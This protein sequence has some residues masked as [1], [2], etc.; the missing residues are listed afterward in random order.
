MEGR[1][2]SAME[3]VLGIG[4]VLIGGAALAINR[5]PMWGWAAASLLTALIAAGRLDLGGGVLLLI[6]LPGLLLAALSH[7]GLRA[8]FV[9]RPLYQALRSTFPAIS[10]T[11]REALAAGTVGWDAQLFRGTLDWARLKAIPAIHL[12]AEER[13]F[14]DGP[15]EQ[16][17]RMID[18]W[19]LRH[20]RR[21]VPDEVWDFIRRKGF[22]G[23]LISKRY[24]GLGFS[25]QA[26]SL[27]LGK[28][29]SRSPDIAVVVMVPNSLGP[30][31]LVE[32][33]GTEA[34]KGAYLHRLARG[35]EV[36]CFALTSPY[37]GSDA[38]S[39]RDVGF[40]CEGE[41]D[42]KQ[43][44]G[45]RL[46]WDKRYIT[47]APKATLLGL[48]F[49]L[50]DP[51][52]L[53]DLDKD[54]IGI[55]VALIPTRHEGVV[56]GHRH[57][58]SGAAF[59]NGPTSGTD[60]F[61]PLD[62]VIGG[63]EQVGHGW[64][65]LMES[66]AVGRAISLPA[67][68]TA[69]IKGMLRVTSAYARLRRQFGLPIGQ[70][71]GVEEPL[72]RLVEN[73]Y[74]V[75]AGRAMTAALVGA[76]QKPSVISALL[77]YSSTE[78]MRRSISDAMDVH[79]G[80]AI[81]D[82][83]ANYLMSA[84]QSVPVGITVEGANIL[85][86]TLI[87]FA[88]GALRCHPYLYRETEALQSPDVVRGFR[89]FERAFNEHVSW[90]LANGT[91]ALLHNL[92]LGRFAGGPGHRAEVERWYRQLARASRSFA[93]VADVTVGL[94]AGG[95]KTKQKITGRLADALSELYLLSAMLKRFDDDGEPQEDLVILELCARNALYRFELALQGVID[96][97]P[98]R[99]A[100]LLMRLVAQ[101]LGVTVKPAPDRLARKAVAGVLVP[102]EQRDR[103][104]R[105]IFVS[106]DE[107]DLTGVLEVALERATGLERAEKAIEK[108]V[109]SG[110]I[111]RHHRSDWLAEAVAQGI[112]SAEDGARLRDFE[113]L[114]ARV[115]GVDDFAPDTVVP[116]YAGSG[117]ETDSA[118]D[119][120]RIAAE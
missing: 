42:G 99:W 77:K 38:A 17:C 100:A 66:L 9:S 23:M 85:T 119:K 89:Q 58:P 64:G 103:L 102:G 65:M 29:A 14:L 6:L 117:D 60:V 106:H 39:M 92:T 1:E 120:S 112:I 71:E 110:R 7:S 98:I 90:A 28:I 69:A 47:L 61:I 59:P 57:L 33:Y 13:D 93:F 19:D 43:V 91:Q 62:W 108:A 70:M 107:R 22:L 46:T 11:E 16:L 113:R 35:D 27:I 36:P 116:H 12:T 48:A 96:N 101:P 118:V 86:R 82:G 50:Y 67:T 68:S 2:F 73:A 109:R 84:Y 20:N 41:H 80:R 95:L 52:R 51:E 104:T 115:V 24:G 40:V 78:R 75:E 32:K 34:Q 5:A 55:T 76:G 15:T 31:E 88:Q 81:C 114:L 26:Q 87:T 63:R 45:I 105:D 72:A 4:L 53:L 18:D 83:P 54:Y 74:A 49:H 21:D 3:L 8:R 25:A 79:G 94:L 30:G 10:D 56:I 44:L 111:H 97:F 37:A